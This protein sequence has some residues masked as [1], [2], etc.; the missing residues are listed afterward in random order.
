MNVAKVHADAVIPSLAHD[1]DAGYD[2]YSVESLDISPGET[3]LVDTGLILEIPYPYAGFILPRSGLAVKKGIT[4][5]N[6]P[7][8]IDSGYRGEVKVGL[9]N[10]RYHQ[11][12]KVKKGD[13]IA[14]IVFMP[15]HAYFKF[16]EKTKKELE[17]TERNI[18]GFGSSGY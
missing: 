18:G 10:N 1:G 4:I 17:N 12:Y 9:H 6:S 7:G 3:R 5:P 16:K 2:L 14:Q 8:L 13:R 11:R 15:V